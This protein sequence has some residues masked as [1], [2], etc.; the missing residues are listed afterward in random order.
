MTY[1][2]KQ[3]VT[4]DLNMTLLLTS[5]V[6]H[7]STSIHRASTETLCSPTLYKEKDTDWFASVCFPLHHWLICVRAPAEILSLLVLASSCHGCPLLTALEDRLFVSSLS[8]RVFQ[9]LGNIQ[10]C[11]WVCDHVKPSSVEC[12]LTLEFALDGYTPLC[13]HTLTL[14]IR[15][16]YTV[17]WLFTLLQA[18]Y[19]GGHLDLSNIL[20]HC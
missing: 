4:E 3:K 11:R 12:T 16:I 20:V 1:K 5:V 15:Y 19:V 10:R 14:Y 7:F 18:Q 13:V 17:H 8:D 9:V 2:L 6:T